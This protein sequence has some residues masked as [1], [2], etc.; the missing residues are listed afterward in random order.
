MVSVPG[1]C[2]F[3]ISLR[4]QCENCQVLRIIYDHPTCTPLP[5][6][7]FRFLFILFF[8]M[9]LINTVWCIFASPHFP[10]K[11]DNDDDEIPDIN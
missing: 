7:D 3:I 1:F 10:D 6:P 9:S 11:E 8:M 4:A 5:H 2:S